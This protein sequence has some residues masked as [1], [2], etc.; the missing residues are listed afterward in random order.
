MGLRYPAPDGRVSRRREGSCTAVEYSAGHSA[1]LAARCRRT[2]A[3]GPAVGHAGP[4]RRLRPWD[5]QPR[6]ARRSGRRA[7]DLR[8]TERLAAAPHTIGAWASTDGT[9]RTLRPQ[10]QTALTRTPPPEEPCRAAGPRKERAVSAVVATVWALRARWSRSMVAR[11]R[12]LVSG[13]HDQARSRCWDAAPRRGRGP[14][15]RRSRGIGGCGNGRP[16]G[17]TD[18]AGGGDP[19]DCLVQQPFEGEFRAAGGRGLSDQGLG[20][21]QIGQLGVVPLNVGPR[22]TAS[23]AARTGWCRAHAVT[24]SRRPRCSDSGPAQLI[25]TD[26]SVPHDAHDEGGCGGSRKRRAA[27]HKAEQ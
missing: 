16:R 23:S 19:V 3:E 9:T 21:G 17:V 24:T 27:R 5:R 14:S 18:A 7:D 4:R 11:Y 20:R 25:C 2:A 13:E 10:S 26:R 6:T 15:R 1:T 8:D 22:L 12:L